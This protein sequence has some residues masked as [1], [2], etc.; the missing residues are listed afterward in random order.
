MAK[1]WN[2]KTPQKFTAVHTSIH[3]HFNQDRHLNR[4]DIFK[5]TRSTGLA[6]WRRLAA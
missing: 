3:N 2:I 5:Q 4:R 6:E 1:F